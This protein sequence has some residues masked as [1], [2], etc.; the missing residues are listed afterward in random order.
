MKWLLLSML[1]AVQGARFKR[2]QNG[3]QKLIAGIPVLNYQAGNRKWIIMFRPGTDDKSIARLCKGKCN[4]VGHPSEGGVGF[5]AI[6]GD[7]E[8]M[9]QALGGRAAQVELLEPDVMDE[10]VPEVEVAGDYP[11]SWGI[12]RIGSSSKPGGGAGVHIYVQD[13]G[14]R[15]THTQFGGRA[16]AAIDLTSDELVECTGEDTSC[17]LDRHSHGT[18]CAGTAGGSTYGVAS[19]ALLYAA[20]TLSDKGPGSRSWQYAAIDWVAANGRRPS[21]MSVSIGGSGNQEGYAASLGAATD[22]GVTV[23]VAAGNNNDDAC[24]FCPSFSEHA[25]TVGATSPSNRRADFSNYGSCVDIMAPGSV[26]MSASYKSD[27]GIASMSGTSMACPHVSGAVALLLEINPTLKRDQVME[28]LAESARTSYITG[29]KPD[30]PDLFL[31]IGTEDPTTVAPTTAPTTCPSH[32]SMTT[33]DRD[34]DCKCKFG[35]KCSVTGGAAWDCP[36]AAGIGG[37]GGR[38]FAAG[39]ETCLCYPA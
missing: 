36:T 34:G 11:E 30:D 35:T 9:L 4:L 14:I 12:D 31:W 24:N 1:C 6:H 10:P 32:S 28:Q 38:Y 15:F 39:C 25:I 18:H 26:I 21:V 16:T 33:P 8:F 7:E 2:R 13:T 20:K 27:T 37:W 29:L 23:V 22:A 5:A 19:S 17:A 3:T